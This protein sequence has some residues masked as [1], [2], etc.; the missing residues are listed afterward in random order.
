MSED[1]ARTEKQSYQ[2]NNII[3]AN[4]DTEAFVN[5][6][7]SKRNN[8]SDVDNWSLKSLKKIVKTY[9][10]MSASQ[11]DPGQKPGKN[12]DSSDS[13]GEDSDN[14]KEENPPENK[15]RVSGIPQG[16]EEDRKLEEEEE[17]SMRKSQGIKA[18]QMKKY[19]ENYISKTT[20]NNYQNTFKSTSKDKPSD[21]LELKDQ[22]IVVQDPKQV[23]PGMFHSTYIEYTIVTTPQNWEVKRRFSDFYW[24]RNIL[25]Q[26]F[27]FSYI[28]PM[29]KKNMNKNFE[30][31]WLNRRMAFMQCFMNSLT[32]QPELRSSPH[33]Q[34]FL[35]VQ[36]PKH[37][38]T[39]KDDQS[40]IMSPQTNFR[41]EYSKK[42]MDDKNSLRLQ[43]LRSLSGN[44]DSKITEDYTSFSSHLWNYISQTHPHYLRAKELSKKQLVDQDS[45]CNTIWKISDCTANLHRANEKFNEASPLG[46][47]KPMAT[48]YL[49]VTNTFTT[50][51]NLISKQV[52]IMQE[53]LVRPL[54]YARHEQFAF[55]DQLQLRNNLGSDYLKLYKNLEVKKDKLIEK[56]QVRD[57]GLEPELLSLYSFEEL[58]K[59]NILA[60][61]QILPKEQKCLKN[62]QNLFGYFNTKIV[63][64]WENFINSKSRRIISNFVELSREAGELMS[65]EI[66]LFSSQSKQLTNNWVT[67]A[68][69]PSYFDKDDLERFTIQG[70]QTKNDL[71]GF[72]ELK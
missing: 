4:E 71:K 65:N 30:S 64:E 15:P 57:W 42:I 26:E 52:K 61:R 21:L 12:S 55:R 72:K 19:T 56:G 11:R 33:L 13:C 28:P 58:Q 45:I 47:F 59:D 5:F 48:V 34:A 29:A 23:K 43:D 18:G 62:M 6:I 25:V 17:Q 8:G 1:Q 50:W 7:S 24:L 53:Y 9:K 36:D 67:M 22:K 38:N 27:P 70:Q 68:E 16:N 14:N 60:K 69:P 41:T 44:Q 49:D 46:S 66:Y 54:K 40:K 39:I 31:A 51:G 10:K 37:F 20:F 32:E 2:R 35:K 63:Q 3:E